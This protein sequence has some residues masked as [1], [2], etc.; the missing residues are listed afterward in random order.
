LPKVRFFSIVLLAGLSGCSRPPTSVVLVSIDTLRPDHLGCYG[1]PRP[2]SPNL[3]AF[4][5]DAILFTNTFAHAPSTIES[6]GAILTSLLPPHHSASVADDLAVPPEVL[7]L[8]EVMRSAGYATASFNGGVQLDAAYGL[9]QGFDIYVSAKPRGT[10]AESMGDETDRFS[11]EVEQAQPWIEQQQGRPFFLFLHT[12]EVHHPYAP[13]GPDLDHFRGSYHGTLPDRITV[14]LLREFN[15]GE[16]KLEPEDRKHIVD[17]YDAEIRSADRSFGRLVA[18]L[19]NLGLYD[20]AL[21]VVT[22]DHGEEFGEHGRV[23]WHAHT[24][25]DELL[26]VPLLVKLPGTTRAGTTVEETVR[27]I[28]VAPT[29]LAAL[30]RSVPSVFEGRDVLAAGPRPAET[31]EVW[32]RRDIRG[33]NFMALRT[34]EW[35]LVDGR[36]Y[37]LRRD[38]REQTDVAA[39]EP[40]VVE[41]MKS[42]RL[43]IL[44]SRPLP[45]P[46]P[47]Q[48]N[49]ELRQRLR[50]LGY[51]D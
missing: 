49:E 5:K 19:R 46:R 40:K 3:D 38:P 51:L 6:H 25:Y 30:G 13:H 48:V 15:L 8:A 17:A 45:H 35:K 4:R 41:R 36:L 26:H 21:I 2:T 20:D 43:E 14:R 47:A 23:G 27:G 28:D 39:R 18:Q 9:D 29:M 7:T 50:S 16:R 33:P 12:Y 10:Q 11:Y 1:Y 34:P 22:S 44:G 32:S 24:L 42:R 31:A 37:D